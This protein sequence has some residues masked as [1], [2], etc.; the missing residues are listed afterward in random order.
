MAEGTFVE[1]VAEKTEAKDR[2]G[3][4]VTGSKRVAIEEAGE[5]LIVIFL[6]GDNTK[7]RSARFLYMRVYNNRVPS[8]N[9]H[10]QNVG[11]NAIAR[12]ETMYIVSYRFGIVVWKLWTYDRENVGRGQLDLRSIET[13]SLF[14]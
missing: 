3:K 12:A 1:R 7:K 4:S 8:E 13:W 5:G 9:T 6:A 14:V 11:L 2:E 10:F